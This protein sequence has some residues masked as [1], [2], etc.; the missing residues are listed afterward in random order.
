[1]PFSLVCHFGHYERAVKPGN[2]GKHNIITFRV[3]QQF[4]HADSCS[5]ERKPACHWSGAFFTRSPKTVVDGNI[6]DNIL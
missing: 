6:R 5:Q 1:M 3:F 4:T 2:N